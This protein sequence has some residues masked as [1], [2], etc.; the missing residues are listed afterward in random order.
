MKVLVT[1]GRHYADRER[2]YEEL[3]K[4]LE[5][6]AESVLIIQGGASGADRL[7][8]GWA[9]ERSQQTCTFPYPSGHGR[10]G[11]PFRNSWMFRAIDVDFVLAFPGGKGTEDTVRRARILGKDLEVIE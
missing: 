7:A 3:D 5:S 1:G 9:N 8:R 10:S 6:V 4:L 11:G 2:V